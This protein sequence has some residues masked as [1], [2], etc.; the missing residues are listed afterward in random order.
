MHFSKI[1]ENDWA[2][3][4]AFL[5]PKADKQNQYQ[6][7]DKLKIQIDFYARYYFLLIQKVNQSPPINLS[8]F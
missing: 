5:D 7:G 2:F 8:A 3:E 6:L 4:H 1:E